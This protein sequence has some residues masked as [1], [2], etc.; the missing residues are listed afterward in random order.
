[1]G[2]RVARRIPTLCLNWLLV[3]SCMM[4]STTPMDPDVSFTLSELSAC[5]PVRGGNS[6]VHVRTILEALAHA[7]GQ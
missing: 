5:G 2:Y 3:L 1:M 4:G 6:V 7:R